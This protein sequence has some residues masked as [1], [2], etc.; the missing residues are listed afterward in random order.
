VCL[1][2]IVPM[3]HSYISLK[4]FSNNGIG[5]FPKL[6]VTVICYMEMKLILLNDHIF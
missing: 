1:K 6:L 2:E 4:D 5:F 3:Y